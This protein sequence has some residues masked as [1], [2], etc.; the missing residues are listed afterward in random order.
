L[1]DITAYALAAAGVAVLPTGAETL[2]KNDADG[3]IT[4][5]MS[6]VTIEVAVLRLPNSV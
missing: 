6:A 5:T 4:I 1:G 2:F 3:L